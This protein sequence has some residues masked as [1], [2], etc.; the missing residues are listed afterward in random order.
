VTQITETKSAV[1]VSDPY[2]MPAAER[3]AYANGLAAGRP[4]A[5]Q[6]EVALVK[7]F[8][9]QGGRVT[10]VTTKEVRRLP[11]G[12][13]VSEGSRDKYLDLTALAKAIAADLGS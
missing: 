13:H 1:D 2:S 3:A 12:I 8:R 5:K 10:G 7:W 4:S 9:A 6:I 11:G